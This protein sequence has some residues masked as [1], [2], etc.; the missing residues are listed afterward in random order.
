MP[1]LHIPW[2]G[3]NSPEAQTRDLELDRNSTSNASSSFRDF[4]DAEEMDDTSDGFGELVVATA[5]GL[6]VG[7]QFWTVFCNEVCRFAAQPSTTAHIL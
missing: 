1:A 7:K 2:P 6:Q 3:S 4:K 5:G